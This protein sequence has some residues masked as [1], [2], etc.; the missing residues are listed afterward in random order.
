MHLTEIIMSKPK[1]FNFGEVIEQIVTNKSDK[2]IF[3]V[4]TQNK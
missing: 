1:S 4:G 3:S 2:R